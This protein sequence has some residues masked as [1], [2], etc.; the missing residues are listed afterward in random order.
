MPA[1]SGDFYNAF[2]DWTGHH[3]ASEGASENRIGGWNEWRD[4]F[5]SIDGIDFSDMSA[6]EETQMFSDFLVAFYPDEGLSG[7]DWD[8]LRV[9]FFADYDIDPD[10]FD[11]DA[12]RHAMGY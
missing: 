5:H 8:D 6:E 11:W 9:D 2:A 12:W 3:G 1:S 4:V 10:D 7:S